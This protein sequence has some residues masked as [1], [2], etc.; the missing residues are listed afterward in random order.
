MR[1]REGEEEIDKEENRGSIDT[2]KNLLKITK[3]KKSETQM[4]TDTVTWNAQKRS[5][6]CLNKGTHNHHTLN[7]YFA[8][9]Q[10][11]IQRILHRQARTFYN[12]YHNTMRCLTL[13]HKHAD[14][15]VFSQM[16]WS[17]QKKGKLWGEKNGK[18]SQRIVFS[19]SIF[20]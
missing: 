8:P 3:R 19:R 12:V 5:I 7:V 11:R 13:T 16:E 4:C 18:E 20:I 10:W 17:N 1:K 15:L 14:N 9:C 6:W 2:K